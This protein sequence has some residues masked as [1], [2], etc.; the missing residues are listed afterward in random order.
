[1]ARSKSLAK[2]AKGGARKSRSKPKSNK[3]KKDK[4]SLTK[5]KIVYRYVDK[6]G[7]K[8]SK[9]QRKSQRKSGQRKSSSRSHM[10]L[11]EEPR[12]FYFDLY[13]RRME[14][15][16]VARSAAPE[17]ILRDPCDNKGYYSCD[18]SKSI[19]CYWTGDQSSGKCRRH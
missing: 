16:P 2:L 1:M 7:K 4:K 17:V 6:S 10:R 13:Q 5:V 3:K 14:D 19:G 8:K 12:N 18:S 11:R 9:S 15:K